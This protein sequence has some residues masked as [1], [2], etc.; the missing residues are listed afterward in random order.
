MCISVRTFLPSISLHFQRVCYKTPISTECGRKLFGWPPINPPPLS[1]H[2]L[3]LGQP[4]AHL[5]NQ[6]EKRYHI[7][8]WICVFRKPNSFVFVFWASQPPCEKSNTLK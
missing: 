2:A 3:E 6:I 4:V 8:T 5:M 1:I 7:N